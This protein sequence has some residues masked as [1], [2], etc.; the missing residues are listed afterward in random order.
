MNKN[1]NLQHLEILK[2]LKCNFSLKQTRV[3]Y[4]LK[5]KNKKVQ[6]SSAV[7]MMN[8]ITNSNNSHR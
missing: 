3:N 7:K 4:Q 8:P 5:I 1:Q 2:H 6:M